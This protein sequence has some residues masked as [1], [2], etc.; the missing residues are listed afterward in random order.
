MK[1]LFDKLRYDGQGLSLHQE[2]VITSFV[3]KRVSELEARLS[4]HKQEEDFQASR[5][6]ASEALQRQMREALEK[7]AYNWRSSS[8]FLTIDEYVQHT[9]QC[10][11]NE[12]ACACGATQS[13]NTF[14]AGQEAIDAVLSPSP[15]PQSDREARRRRQSRE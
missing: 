6:E 15:A 12:N 7:M 1:E 13:L 4:A 5:A 2:T 3:S 9:L 8:A 14:Y 10:A 11:A